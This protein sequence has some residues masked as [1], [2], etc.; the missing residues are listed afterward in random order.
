[1]L[2]LFNESESLECELST[3]PRFE[4]EACGELGNGL[5]AWKK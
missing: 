4:T 5:V 1:M 3:Y 2:L